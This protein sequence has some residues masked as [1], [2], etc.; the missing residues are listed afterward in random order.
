MGRS[1]IRHVLHN[2]SSTNDAT[3]MPM[4]QFVSAPQISLFMLLYDVLTVCRRP[5]SLG[6]I[7]TGIGH[8]SIYI[9]STRA[10]TVK[11]T[12]LLDSPSQIGVNTFWM[13]VLAVGV[14]T[15]S[16]DSNKKSD[17][18]PD[19]DYIST[20]REAMLKWMAL[21]YSAHQIGLITS[22]TEVLTADKGVRGY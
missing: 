20:T 16:V 6:Y 5:V 10:A 14:V 9:S 22:L 1:E 19:S 2:I 12:L 4:A 11:R 3:P 7:N 8:V 21:L 15:A 17:I 13:G 18:G